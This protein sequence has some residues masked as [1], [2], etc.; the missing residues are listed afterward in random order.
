MPAAGADLARASVAGV[1]GSVPATRLSAAEPPRASAP[2]KKRPTAMLV[3]AGALAFLT[4][5]QQGQSLKVAAIA[6]GVQLIYNLIARIGVE[7]TI[8]QLAASK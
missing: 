2:T 3:G 8:D 5:L 4:G 6:G 1:G 7:G